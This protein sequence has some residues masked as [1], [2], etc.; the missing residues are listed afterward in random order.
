MLHKIVAFALSVVILLTFAGCGPTAAPAEVEEGPSSE[1]QVLTWADGTA[2]LTRVPCCEATVDKN[3][4]FILDQMFDGLVEYEPNS[5]EITSSLAESWTVSSDGRTWTF[6]LRDDVT[7]NDGTPLTAE[8]VAYSI[9]L[10]LSPE[11]PL[12]MRIGE[13][14]EIVAVDEHTVEITT[15][16]PNSA[17]L[18]GLQDVVGLIQSPNSTP[19]N[20]IGTGPYVLRDWNRGERVILERRSDYWGDEPSLDRIVYLARP[21]DTTRV[22]Q[23]LNGEIEVAAKLPPESIED[24][25][26][27]DGVH[28][29]TPDS[30]MLVRISLNTRVSPYDEKPVRQA[31]NYA[32]DKEAIVEDILLGAGYVPDAMAG[33]GVWGTV[34]FEEGYYP[35]DLERAESLLQEAGFERVSDQWQRDGEPLTFR[36]LVP[37]GRYM[38]DRV[39]GEFVAQQLEDFGVAV[40]LEV[41]PWSI[42]ASVSRTRLNAGEIDGWLSGFSLPHPE[43]NWANHFHCSNKDRLETGY[44]NLEFDALVDEARNTFDEEEQRELY[45]EAQRMLADEAIVLLLYGQSPVW[46]V[47]DS[48]SGLQWSINEIPIVDE[49]SIE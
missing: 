35:Y 17:L 49:V 42:A 29:E 36:L 30:S 48:V 4:R 9:E 44:C 39:V 6:T 13:I 47:R 33:H 19:E 16:S 8:A 3:T 20:P 40:E 23:L 11:S 43:I 12:L 25:E 31:F 1:P 46:G 37:E 26:A 28:P 41:S 7:F 27:T 24:L 18:H 10:A 34:T 21:E 32:V 2:I 22:I 45:A 5:A 38:K 14:E 15:E